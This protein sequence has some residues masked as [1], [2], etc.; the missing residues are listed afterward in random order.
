MDIISWLA[1]T[2]LVAT[3]GAVIYAILSAYW[4][5]KARSAEASDDSA[6][7]RAIEANTAANEAV[8]TRLQALDQRVASVEKILTETP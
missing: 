3:A 5:T 4:K 8:L 1:L 6:L 7:R 2:P